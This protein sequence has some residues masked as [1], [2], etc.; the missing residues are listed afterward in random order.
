M[1]DENQGEG[2]ITAARQYNEKTRQFVKEGNV[3][4]KAAEAAKALDGSEA[5]ELQEA[6]KKGKDKAAEE[7]P[8]V[9]RD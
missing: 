4:E 1:A 2:N 6:E 8:Q 7:D 3:G 5:S 9:H